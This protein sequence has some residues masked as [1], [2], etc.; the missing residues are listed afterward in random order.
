MNEFFGESIHWT[1]SLLPITETAGFHQ[2]IFAVISC[3]WLILIR[4]E[5]KQTNV[6]KIIDDATVCG[7]L[8]IIASFMRVTGHQVSARGSDGVPKVQGA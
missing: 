8:I 7:Y 1:Q 5:M 3:Q 2:I 4:R 6:L